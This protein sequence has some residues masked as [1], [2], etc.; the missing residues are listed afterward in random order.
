M[1]ADPEIIDHCKLY[2]VGG[3]NIDSD[4]QGETFVSGGHFIAKAIC[5]KSILRDEMDDE[6][7]IKYNHLTL[8]FTITIQNRHYCRFLV[9]CQMVVSDEI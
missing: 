3:H 2:D 1:I 5:W 7:R 4:G 9:A 6:M 8:F